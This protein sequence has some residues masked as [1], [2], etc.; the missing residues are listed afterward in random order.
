[1]GDADRCIISS[2]LDNDLYKFTMQNAVFRLFP[3]AVVEYR[4][5]DRGQTQW[6]PGFA[7]RLREQIRAY[8]ELKFA[9][10]EIEFLQKKCPYLSPHYL[11]WLQG[12][13]PDP[14]EVWITDAGG[15]LLDLG[16]QGPWYRTILWEVPLMAMISELRYAMDP[17]FE[18]MS[19]YRGNDIGKA[20]RMRLIAP[21]W[22]F[23]TRR[24][25]SRFNQERI[26][27]IHR[28]YG[29]SNFK[30]TSN[31]W[32]AQKYNLDPGGTTAHEWTMF[33]GMLC[34]F[35]RANEEALR[36]WNRVY[37]GDLGIA[38]TDTYTSKLFFET[39]SAPMAL[40]YDGLRQDSGD[41]VDFAFRAADF[42]MKH[43]ID[44]KTKTI[45]FSDGL[46]VD[47]AQEIK[48]ECKGLNAKPMFGIGT[49]FTNDI[50]GIPPMNMV[51]KMVAATEHPVAPMIPTVKLSDAKGKHTG[52]PKAV[53][54][55]EWEV[56]MYLKGEV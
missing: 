55:C 9:P 43:G 18:N 36:N 11:E 21:Y 54:H 30:G 25:Y 27:E 7:D 13:R 19:F 22:E 46:T 5:I 44:S 52:D 28:K 10:D 48:E 29:G 37:Q 39:V 3:D 32:M 45:V 17:A 40:V 2:L 35:L 26:V 53:E 23:G 15:E 49:H 51:I 24:R 6:P 50:Q 12:Y 34:G 42:Y 56:G 41:P 1:M 33:H 16:I 14:S 38:L 4:F 8:C 31:V 47:R 20:E